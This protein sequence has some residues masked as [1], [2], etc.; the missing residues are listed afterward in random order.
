MKI[1]FQ[2]PTKGPLITVEFES[3]A[4]SVLGFVGPAA[5]ETVA[6]LRAVANGSTPLGATSGVASAVGPWALIAMLFSAG[7]SHPR[8][9]GAEPTI[10]NPLSPD[11]LRCLADPYDTSAECAAVR[12]GLMT[13]P[14][15][16]SAADPTSARAS[17]NGSLLQGRHSTQYV[18]LATEP[19]AV[20]AAFAI[21]ATSRGNTVVPPVDHGRSRL[22]V[23]VVPITFS[24]DHDPR[25]IPDAVVEAAHQFA[26]EYKPAPIAVLWNSMSH[27]Y[28]LDVGV[29]HPLLFDPQKRLVGIVK[30]LRILFE[31]DFLECVPT[32][33]DL[34]IHRKWGVAPEGALLMDV[35]LHDAMNTIALRPLSLA[36]NDSSDSRWDVYKMALTHFT[37]GDA[38]KN[39]FIVAYEHSNPR[40]NRR[41]IIPYQRLMD[42]KDQDVVIPGY[43]TPGVD[44]YFGSKARMW[45]H[46]HWDVAAQ[47]VNVSFH[48]STISSQL[49]SGIEANG[50]PMQSSIFIASNKN[51][52]RQV[53]RF[54]I[55]DLVAIIQDVPEDGPRLGAESYGID[56]VN[57]GAPATVHVID[58]QIKSI[59]IDGHT[60]WYDVPVNQIEIPY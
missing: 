33:D 30:D 35:I 20:A 48:A 51:G 55:D 8:T 10:A 40:T 1:T 16:E 19:T 46:L 2:N 17:A 59:T 24:A 49:P 29:L 22:D 50:G 7:D 58:G 57:S 39:Y 9:S 43:I 60:E 42:A 14:A 15:S 56:D 41:L 4:S 31:S 28:E 38:F 34:E 21:M 3:D 5:P 54:K 11:Q 47:K 12:S 13:F 53:Y 23:T 37:P 25:Q 45:L 26:A 18:P 27:H 36:S 44:E 32:H 6:K 52:Q